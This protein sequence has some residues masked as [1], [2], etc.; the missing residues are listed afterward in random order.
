MGERP[1]QSGRAG[2]HAERAEQGLAQRP[3]VRS[4]SRWRATTYPVAATSVS[5]KRVNASPLPGEPATSE[6]DGRETASHRPQLACRDAQVQGAQLM[7]MQ[8]EVVAVRVLHVDPDG[9]T[10]A[11]R[12]S[13]WP[14]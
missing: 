8:L 2:R 6:W 5:L 3:G 9:S 10:A 12:R 7:D 1:S 14:Q 11:S 4:R 13:Q